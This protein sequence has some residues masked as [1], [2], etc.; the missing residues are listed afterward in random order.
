VSKG[1]SELSEGTM[2]FGKVQTPEPEDFISHIKVRGVY[3]ERC[4]ISNT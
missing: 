3:G 1:F 2:H 4:S